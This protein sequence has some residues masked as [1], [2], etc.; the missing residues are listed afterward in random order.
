[1]TQPPLP[2]KRRRKRITST[3]AYRAALERQLMIERMN[4]THLR[5]E[6]AR[7]GGGSRGARRGEPCAVGGSNMEQ[8]VI[9]AILFALWVGLGLALT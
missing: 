5:P 3:N 7:S 1:M 9:A 6:E 8:T 2:L 4:S